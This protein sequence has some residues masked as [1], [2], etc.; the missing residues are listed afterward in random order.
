[1]LK[2]AVITPYY[3]ESL[4]QLKK[5]HESVLAQGS[6]VTHFLVSD[7][8]PQEAIDH[9]NCIHI[10]LPM[11]LNDYGDTPRGIGAAIASAQLYDGIC[12]LDADNW[13]EPEHISN[14]RQVYNDYQSPVIS[15]AR[16][17]YLK[18]NGQYLG[19]CPDCD[20]V[21]FVDTS[22]YFF[23]RDAFDVCRHWLFKAEGMGV[24]D[25]RIIW[26]EVLRQNIKRTHITTPTVN[27][28]TDF[29]VHYEQF[30]LI[31]PPFSRVLNA[32]LFKFITL[33]E[34]LKRMQPS[35]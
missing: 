4:E 7:G 35:E 29:A 9:W 22:C 13:Y 6:N 28:V 18:E 34:A 20:G 17:L 21:N 1:M 11:S 31:A 26:A 30:G 15:T 19:I 5:C 8:I 25:D 14:I 24:I 12:F 2:I 10:K 16:H 27:Y 3:K 23:H 32:E 33:E